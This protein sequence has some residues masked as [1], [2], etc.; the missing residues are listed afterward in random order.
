MGIGIVTA[1]KDTI[2]HEEQF[3]AGARRARR[4]SSPDSMAYWSQGQWL[5]WWLDSMDIWF[6]VPPRP[7]RELAFVPIRVSPEREDV[8]ETVVSVLSRL[9]QSEHD[10]IDG[11][12]AL[13][14]E[15]HEKIENSLNEVIGRRFG[16]LDEERLLFL[17]RIAAALRT[18]RTP[19]IIRSALAAYNYRWI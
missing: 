16:P 14:L 15:R 1:L 6:S 4:R 8:V 5:D 13:S 7:D 11:S 17:L 19:R 18:R 12:S 2:S 10:T 9:L 3:V